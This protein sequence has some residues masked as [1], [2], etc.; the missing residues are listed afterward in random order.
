MNALASHKST[1]L[2]WLSILLL[3]VLGLAFLLPVT[4]NDFWWYV[5][6][7][8]EI[9]SRGE[10]PV[11]DTLSSTQA[12]VP[13]VYHSW[14]PAVI[15]WV[16][17]KAGGISLIVLLRGILVGTAYTL[18]WFFARRMGA[19]VRLSSVLVFVAALSGSNN[20]A[21]RPQLFTY[22]IFLLT[23]WVLWD[24]HQGKNK[25]LWTFP[26]LSFLWVNVHGS[27]VLIFLLGGA[28]LIFGRGDRRAL[29]ISL[30]VGALA[31][32]LNPRGWLAWKYVL[33]MLSA[34]SNQLFS[35]E[36]QPPFN[37]NWQMNIFFIWMLLFPLFVAVSSW[38][39]DRFAWALYLIFGVLAF[40]GLRYVIWEIF[41]LVIL[42]A[43]LLAEFGNRWLDKPGRKSIPTFDYILSVIFVLLSFIFLP[44]VRSSI[45]TGIPQSLVY[46][47]TPVEA[48]QWLADHPEL[49]GP[50]WADLAF[51]SYLVYVLPERPVWIDTRFEVYP[52]EQ[53]EKF[54][55]V[56]L[57]R[58]DWQALLDEAGVNLLMISRVNQPDLLTA[59]EKSSV[60][61]EVY[62]DTEAVIFTRCD[63]Q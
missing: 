55:A 49:P 6:V 17:Y 13:V 14:L 41:I 58:W 50:L 4:P 5:R 37:N 11:V 61:C 38:R 40:S 23:L 21:V 2:L 34:P 31:T 46:K 29:A 48:A 57:A 43:G 51:S 28:A 52:V 32:L 53:W 63:R 12:G 62:Q 35:R 22:V 9:M 47:D 19:G 26:I 30:G 36:W 1:N 44:N 18:L 33:D 60:W 25:L 8:S 3:I 24:W 7:G 16:F 45:M 27:F 10:I 20:W 42:S 39:L 56:N 54:K 59:L 15:F